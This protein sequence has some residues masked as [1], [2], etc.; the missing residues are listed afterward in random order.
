MREK[1]GRI[2]AR[3]KA[4]VHDI[5]AIVK[6]TINQWIDDKAFKMSA[7][8]SFYSLF[9]LF[10]VLLITVTVVGKI[11]G[12]K[13]LRG[14]IVDAIKD[15]VGQRGAETIQSLLGNMTGQK[16]AGLAI[17]FSVLFIIISSVVVFV[18]LKES[19]NVIWGV[20]LKPGQPIKNL[21]RDRILA[22]AMV[23]GC[24]LLFLLSLVFDSSLKALGQVLKP[25]I[26]QVIPMLQWLNQL[27]L[28][29]FTTLVLV[30]I[31]R[32]LPD[33]KVG[34]RYLFSGALVTSVL[35]FIGRH[36][37]GL[38]MGHSGWAS[39]YGAAGSL[40]AL[41]LW[42]YYSALIFYFGAELT[43][44][45]RNYYN[46]TPLKISTHAVAVVKTTKMVAQNIKKNGSKH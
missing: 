13:A 42:I 22:F 26:P 37:I 46:K 27:P 12:R 21:L 33:V 25:Y 29:I 17:V 38:Y 18:E 23:L 39:I 3:C 19:L 44:V 41:L 15:I 34:W 2:P 5:A 14:E 7:A 20:E 1:I 10:P 43:Q 28:F 36:F 30:L 45:V 31:F 9:S 8:V 24:G 16:V 4:M 35:F 6:E 32:V 40:V 11:Y